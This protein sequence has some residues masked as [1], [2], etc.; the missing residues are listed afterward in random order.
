MNHLA[1]GHRVALSLVLHIGYS[2]VQRPTDKSWLHEALPVACVVEKAFKAQIVSSPVLERRARE[3]EQQDQDSS[4]GSHPASAC[5]PIRTVR[6]ESQQYQ[7]LWRKAA[8]LL[9]T[10][11]AGL[12]ETGHV[13]LLSS[14]AH[15]YFT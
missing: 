3:G 9:S 13:F 4:S 5:P 10:Q 7:Y 1:S 8:A 14:S 15:V 11:Q 2:A 12:R 6:V